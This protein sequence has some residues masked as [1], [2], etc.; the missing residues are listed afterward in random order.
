LRDEGLEPVAKW[1]SARHEDLVEEMLEELCGFKGGEARELYAQHLPKLAGYQRGASGE[2]GV[3]EWALNKVVGEARGASTIGPKEALLQFTSE[4]LAA[5]LKAYAPGCWRRLALIAGSALAGYQLALRMAATE[6]K[7][8][9]SE[10]LEPCEADSYLLVDGEISPLF[11]KVVLQRSGVLAHPLVHRHGEAA[12]EL[13]KLVEAW[14]SRGYAYIVEAFYGLGLALAVAGAAELGN[15]VETWEA[16][17]ALHTA[18]FAVQRV[19]EVECA[20]AILDSFRG[21]WELAPHYY[22]LL[23]SAVSELTRLERR[24]T[25][26]LADFLEGALEREEVKVREWPL[27]EAVRTYSDLLTKH[28]VHFL[29]E[30]ERLR[31][32]MCELLEELEGQL[33]DIAEVYALTPALEEGLK[34]CSG[35]DPAGRAE[36]LLK[37]LEEMEKEEPSGQAAE[38]AAVRA[39][40]PEDFKLLVRRLRGTLTYSLAWYKMD[41]DDLEAAKNLFGRSAEIDR[42]L[43][44]WENYLVSRSLAAR[45]SVLGAGSLEELRGRAGAFEGLWSEAKEHERLKMV[46][47]V[48][49]SLA[50]AGY[51][52]FLAL[53][54]RKGEVSEL[55]EREG[56]LLSYLPDLSVTVRLLLELL[57]VGVGKPEA[58]EVATALSNHI[59]AELLPIFIVALSVAICGD[60]EAAAILQGFREWLPWGEGSEEREVVERFRRELLDF[61]DRRGASAVAQLGAPVTSLAS[62]T[63]MLWALVN[64]DEELARAHAK[65][66]WILSESKLP[67]RLFREAAE[68]QGERFKLALLKLFYLHF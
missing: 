56:Q 39:F 51:L 37:R 1:L 18:V 60:R 57:G 4:R 17:V 42:E 33:R 2:Q 11:V 3:L 21:L 23:V 29:G 58:W 63:L 8:L 12:E 64:G 20:T 15:K 67:R 54:G 7:V 30:E 40:K 66:A 65:L 34:P 16:E 25:R 35:A 68:A 45:C 10:A 43:E 24:A 48:K 38:W 32:R 49:E 19:F 59:D 27:V 61:A 50:L 13:E 55:L 14:R 28:W 22:V 46:Y 62:F 47:L 44:D 31:G 52:V 53:E 5:A 41:N 9:P 36:R 6:S 26:E